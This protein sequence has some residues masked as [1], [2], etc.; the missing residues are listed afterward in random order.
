VSHVPLK[1]ERAWLSWPRNVRRGRSICRI[2]A[3]LG[4]APFLRDEILG[5]ADQFSRGP[6]DAAEAHETISYLTQAGGLGSSP[7]IC[8]S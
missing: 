5:G 2:S 7:R 8:W 6:G 3:A 4:V 1:I